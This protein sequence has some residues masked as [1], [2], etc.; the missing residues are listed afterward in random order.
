MAR[1][2]LKSAEYWR[3][4]Y[5]VSSLRATAISVVI[6]PTVVLPVE[7]FNYGANLE[8]L[9]DVSI[10][11][12]AMEILAVITQAYKTANAEERWVDFEF[13]YMHFEEINQIHFSHLFIH[14][15]VR[16]LEAMETVG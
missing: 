12:P 9:N 11:I 15:T 7:L 13:S 6:P 8:L 4:S 5:N 14:H 16:F 3:P 10:S 1:S 2:V